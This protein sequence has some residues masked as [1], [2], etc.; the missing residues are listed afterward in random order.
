MPKM[1]KTITRSRCRV[2]RGDLSLKRVYVLL[3]AYED[4]GIV[5]VQLEVKEYA[6]KDNKLYMAV[7]LNKISTEVKTLRRRQN[8]PLVTASS[9]N[10]ISVR[11]V[12]EKI[13]SSD[14]KFLRYIPDGMLNDE[15]IEAKRAADETSTK[16][17]GANSV[18]SK[19]SILSE[20]GN[21]PS[22]DSAMRDAT[23]FNITL[24]QENSDVNTNIRENAQND[25]QINEKTTD[26][27]SALL[28]SSLLHITFQK[29]GGVFSE[30]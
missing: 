13:N 10:T 3:L 15:Q 30:E 12:V 17:D 23:A 21:S 5:L 9:V 26:A 1:G 2:W 7:T 14:G 29:P 8:S 20:K 24:S 11:E 16:Q 6:N 27:P 18:E 19:S 4:G 22:T 28:Y 25:T